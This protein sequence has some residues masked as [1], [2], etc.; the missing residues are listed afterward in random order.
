[1]TRYEYK[2][3]TWLLGLFWGFS[4]VNSL[5]AGAL[6]GGGPAIGLGATLLLTALIVMWDNRENHKTRGDVWGAAIAHFLLTGFAMA[7]FFHWFI[8]ILYFL[9]LALCLCIWRKK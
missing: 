7:M 8:V 3:N 5:A 6:E 1:M 4:G 9:E 2:R